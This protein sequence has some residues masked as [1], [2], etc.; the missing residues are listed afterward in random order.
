L[1]RSTVIVGSPFSMGR[2]MSRLERAYTSQVYER[3]EWE[4]PPVTDD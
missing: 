4:Q 3:K 2:R 1:C